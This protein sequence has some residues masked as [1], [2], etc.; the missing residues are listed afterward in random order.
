MGAI[1]MGN[2]YTSD[3]HIHTEAS[4]DGELTFPELIK[5]AKEYGITQ[6]GITDHVNF[7]F[8]E[9]HVKESR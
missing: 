5:N 6:F 1:K 4:Y 8:M 7:E 3:W 2:I 9:A